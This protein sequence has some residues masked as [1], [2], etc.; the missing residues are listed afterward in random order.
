MDCLDVRVW[1]QVPA[2]GPTSIVPT[3]M[4]NGYN[5]YRCICI[6]PAASKAEI[7]FN[8]VFCE[9]IWKEILGLDLRDAIC[10]FFELLLYP[11]IEHS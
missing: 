3:Y 4:N 1:Y 7:K 9:I 11:E 6:K 8:H 5:T 10:S 2:A